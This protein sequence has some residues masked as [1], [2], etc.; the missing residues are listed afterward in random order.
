MAEV[1]TNISLSKDKY[2]DNI[3]INMKR[4]FPSTYF[5]EDQFTLEKY[6][7]DL[8]DIEIRNELQNAIKS[9][10][11]FQYMMNDLFMSSSFYLVPVNFSGASTEREYLERYANFSQL[12]TF[13]DI[14]STVKAQN[15]FY[16]DRHSFKGLFLYLYRIVYRYDGVVYNTNY[17]AG[18]EAIESGALQEGQYKRM[19]LN[20]T[21]AELFGPSWT[22]LKHYFTT[23]A[24]EKRTQYRQT[25]TVFHLPMRKVNHRKQGPLEDYKIKLN[26][27]EVTRGIADI[28]RIND[29]VK[30][31]LEKQTKI[32]SELNRDNIDF[33]SS[34]GKDI[35]KFVEDMEGI[36]NAITEGSVFSIVEKNV[37]IFRVLSK[38]LVGK[39]QYN[40]PE[41]M[42][43]EG[44]YILLSSTEAAEEL[45]SYLTTIDPE[46]VYGLIDNI[47]IADVV[48]KKILYTITAG[49]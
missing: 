46:N 34:F 33:T 18:F 26:Y 5:E 2:S 21:M 29:V 6:E 37:S 10:T 32:F 8:N 28:S 11:V 3:V 39:D 25:P 24:R 41:F 7:L 43:L 20:Q 13:I 15:N 40:I 35:N 31:A 42:V 49:K 22:N 17:V 27:K 1:I 12:P 23:E 19:I 36:A 45:Y 44:I 9:Q 14:T 30:T 47:Y 38:S 16:I 4:N 48:N